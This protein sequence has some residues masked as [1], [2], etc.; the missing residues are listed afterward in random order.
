MTR[1]RWSAVDSGLTGGL[2]TDESGGGLGAGVGL[3]ACG[4]RLLQGSAEARV[5]G[6]PGEPAQAGVGEGRGILPA[7]VRHVDLPQ[8]HPGGKRLHKERAHTDTHTYV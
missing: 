7:P 4:V 6:L 2:L 1:S 8:T 5:A 3:E